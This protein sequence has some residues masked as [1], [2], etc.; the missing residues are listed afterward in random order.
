MYRLERTGN[1]GRVQPI[2]GK[3]NVLPLVF[4]SKSVF[5]FIVLPPSYSTKHICVWLVFEIFLSYVRFPPPPP[6]PPVQL[7]RWPAANGARIICHGRDDNNT[8]LIINVPCF[9]FFLCVLVTVCA[10]TRRNET[11]PAGGGDARTVFVF[12]T[13]NIKYRR[14]CGVEG[15]RCD[16]VSL[17]RGT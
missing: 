8:I 5:I 6:A 10:Q 3:I 15:C 13:A 2:I 7:A 1:A 14:R 16:V 11:N 17:L 9:F 4:Q 12:V